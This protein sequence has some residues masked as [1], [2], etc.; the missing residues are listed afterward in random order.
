[1]NDVTTEHITD[2]DVAVIGGGQAALALG[3]YLRRT[4]L[5]YLILDDQ[6]APGGAWRRA[7]DSLRLF[8]PA[9][10]SSL[11]GFQLPRGTNEYPSRDEVVSY[12]A[13]Y[14]RR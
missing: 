10:W 9:Q 8:S 14:E 13:E 3:F 11:P 1:M 5:S 2:I 12:L 7:W 6:D 4:G